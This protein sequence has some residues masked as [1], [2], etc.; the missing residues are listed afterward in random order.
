MNT[1]FQAIRV[2]G[3]AAQ[4]V[5]GASGTILVV[6]AVAGEPAAAAFGLLAL[7][8][9]VTAFQRP[10]LLGPLVA[11][12]LP[13]G[14]YVYLLHD[15]IVPLEAAVGGGALGYLARLAT[16]REER[17]LHAVHW[18]YAAFLVFVA[19]SAL[20]PGPPKNH[21]LA[22]LGALGFVFHAIT[23]QAGGRRNQR[24]LLVGLGLPLLFEASWAIV[25]YIGTWS[26]PAGPG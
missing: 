21:D 14:H 17:R 19:L 24:L 15:S 5:A 12:L 1:Y 9:A 25:E 20:G 3:R 13:A 8:A 7:I 16:T 11:L 18:S 23:T 4:I 10:Y 22:Y 26:E 6:L 2:P